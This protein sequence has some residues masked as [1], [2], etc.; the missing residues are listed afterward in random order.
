ML[1]HSPPLSRSSSLVL[2]LARSPAL[3][4]LLLCFHFTFAVPLLSSPCFCFFSICLPSLLSHDNIFFHPCFRAASPCPSFS[5]LPLSLALLSLGPVI[6]SE[7][8]QIPMRHTVRNVSSSSL[9]LV[10]FL[11]CLP[12]L[13]SS[14]S[15]LSSF[16]LLSFAFS[17][18]SIFS[19][20]LLLNSP[21]SFSFF[22]LTSI[23]CG[24]AK[25]CN[26]Y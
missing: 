16:L 4:P 6:T 10:V 11:S 23:C 9:S 20:F 26:F 19:Y 14:P 2:P 21:T 3:F 7:T 15:F 5:P 8:T 17:S 12:R 18:P 24:M 1:S 25:C 22:R 13:S